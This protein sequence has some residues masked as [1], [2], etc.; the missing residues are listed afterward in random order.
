MKTLLHYEDHWYIL[1]KKVWG[2]R[3]DP[4]A[5]HIESFV[6]QIQIHLLLA[7]QHCFLLGVARRKPTIGYNS[8]SVIWKFMKQ[9]VMIYSVK[10]FFASQQKDFTNENFIIYCL[11]NVFNKANYCMCTRKK[12]WNPN[13][14]VICKLLSYCFKETI[15]FGCKA[16]VCK[17][18]SV[19]SNQVI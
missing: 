19:V 6:F 12:F 14:F 15:G 18:S 7:T 10:Y 13:Q 8:Y 3:T 5:P 9:Y 11:F 17:L 2:P 16:L 1:K 4:K